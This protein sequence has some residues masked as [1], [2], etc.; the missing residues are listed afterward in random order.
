MHAQ[1]AHHTWV[2]EVD[3]FGESHSQ[4]ANQEGTVKADMQGSHPLLVAEMD[5]NAHAV[6]EALSK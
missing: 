2:H 1:G 5:G 4:C 3:E 6:W